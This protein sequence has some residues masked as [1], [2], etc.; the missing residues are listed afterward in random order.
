MNRLCTTSFVLLTV[1][2]MTGCQSPKDL[3]FREF[4]NLTLDKVG[5][6]ASSLKVNLVYYNPNN[7]GMELKRTELDIFIDSTFLGHSS[8]E[9]QVAIPRR[10]VFTVPL[11]IE[12]DMKN[13]FKNGIMAYINKQVA[14]RAVGT[15]K[16]GKAGVYKN[17][18]VDYTTMQQF[19]LF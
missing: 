6:S 18:N 7:F 19:S 10:D 16:V 1:L 14:V 9:L 4:N 3:E 12:L 11:L 5:F 8:Q 13:M 15:I 17:F 2:I